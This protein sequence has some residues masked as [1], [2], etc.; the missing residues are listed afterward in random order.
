MKFAV[1]M[2]TLESRVKGQLKYVNTTVIIINTECMKEIQN[3][4]DQ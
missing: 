4:M 1:F 3:Y 2:K